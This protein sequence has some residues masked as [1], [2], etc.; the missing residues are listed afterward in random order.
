MEHIELKLKLIRDLKSRTMN[1]PL[2]PRGTHL[3]GVSAGVKSVPTNVPRGTHLEGAES[4]NVPRGTSKGLVTIPVV[5]F[6][7]T[8]SIHGSGGTENHVIIKD[9]STVIAHCKI[10]NGTASV[11][12]EGWAGRSHTLLGMLREVGY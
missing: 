1:V 3:E 4:V 10:V 11:V 7:N 2:V 5:D 9:G 12:Q 8:V 6:L